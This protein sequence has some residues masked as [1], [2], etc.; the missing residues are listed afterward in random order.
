[1]STYIGIDGRDA[2]AARPRGVGKSLRALLGR[3]PEAAPDWRF[4]AYTDR[5]GDMPLADRLDVRQITLRGDRVNAW[6]RFRL[7]VAAWW[8]RVNLL[9]CP[10]QTAPPFA[11][12][13]IVLTVHDLIPLRIG[14]GWAARDIQRFRRSLARAVKQAARIIAVSEYT[15]GD[16]LTEFGLP[17]ERVDVVPWGV[18]VPSEPPRDA[19]RFE[20]LATAHRVR[21]PFFVAF[22]GDAPRKNVSRLIEAL[23]ELTRALTGDVQL[24]LIGVPDS[25]RAR[26]EELAEGLGVS[27]QVVT[28]GYLPDQ[29]VATL[30]VFS[31]A[32]VY[33][34]LYE[35]FGLPVLE[36]MAVGAPVI[37]SNTTSLPEVAG[38]AA[39][40]VDPTSAGAIAEAMRHCYLN[41]AVKADLA[42][43]GRRRAAAFTWDRAARATVATYRRVLGS[44]VTR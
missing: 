23:R 10:G 42:R 5:D 35:G 6:E 38:D 18:D 40:L 22:G 32:L 25:A 8:D 27:K 28:L 7:P 16:L 20:A 17:G 3:L 19:G 9:H 34:S 4:T 26:F 29:D 37:T 44:G 21:Q 33:P 11:P 1:M 12:C 14:D 2:F 36:A 41:A 31:E 13:P 15:R 24:V 30:L 43:R 39:L